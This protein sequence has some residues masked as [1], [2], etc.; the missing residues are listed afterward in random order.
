MTTEQRSRRI[1]WDAYSLTDL[2][3]GQAPIIEAIVPSLSPGA[4]GGAVA[5]GKDTQV[6]SFF[7]HNNTQQTVNVT[8][9]NHVKA[10][11]YGENG[12]RYAPLI[13]KKEQIRVF[14]IGNSDK[15]YWEALGR[16]SRLRTL[17]RRRW[18]V[19]ATPVVGQEKTDENTY[20]LETNPAEGYVRLKTSKANKEPFS[21]VL[22]F[23]TKDG[24]FTVTDDAGNKLLIDSA[25]EI[26]HL[27]NKSG[28]TIHAEK[29]NLTLEASDCMTLKA[30]KQLYIESPSYILNKN[31]RGVFVGNLSY[32]T[33]SGTSFVANYSTVGLNATS[34]SIPGALIAGGIR[35]PII[36]YGPRGVG[37]KSSTADPVSVTAN[38]VD[39]TA[40]TE[41]SGGTD[42]DLTAHRDILSA[43]DNVCKALVT[44]ATAAKT[45]VNVAPIMSAARAA[46]V[47]SI[48]GEQ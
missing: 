16:D 28:T 41:V 17:D 15:F 48:K 25:K 14:Q 39:N 47:R 13:R 6:F 38:A 33:L 3:P 34:V 37:Y 27:S 19:S 31:K 32:M 12:E 40:D 46:V 23:N 36:V 35:A 26:L 11:W 2:Q 21:Y 24:S 22:N 20:F 1:E 45:S 30:G 7:D 4:L 29:K 10:E 5:P 18:E 8:T 42:R 9:A 43:F 44:I